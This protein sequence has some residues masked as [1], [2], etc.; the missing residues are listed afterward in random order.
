MH[1]FLVLLGCA[2]AVAAAASADAA[3]TEDPLIPLGRALFFDI[4]L[5]TPAG[6]SCSSC[7]DP[8]V[9]FSDPERDLP[10]SRGVLEDR[11]GS[12]NAQSVAYAAFSPPLH[13]DPTPQPG[14]HQGMYVGGF[15]WDG[16][17][18]T[19]EEQAKEPFLNPLE[20]HNPDKAAVV[21]SVRRAVYAS[22][23]DVACGAGA[24][25][26]VEA[27]F[28]CVAKALAA[29]LRSPALSPFT[30][31][32][33][34][35]RAGRTTLTPAEAR[36]YELFTGKAKCKNCHAT[37]P[38]PEG[39]ILFTNFGHHNTGVPRNPDLPFYRLPASL[40]PVGEK[41]VDRGL[42]DA[43]RKAGAAEA[44]AVRE[45]GKFKVPSLRNVAVTPP[46]MHN[47]VFKTLREVVVFNNTRDVAG[48]PPPE[49]P[50]NVHR[51][52]GAPGASRPAA[53]HGTQGQM[54]VAHQHPA[55]AEGTFGRLGL[56]DQEVDDLV[57]FLM[58]LTD[59]YQPQ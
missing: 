55:S 46:Y 1:R 45:D 53:G 41:H 2:C 37:E 47:G 32:F 36:G 57:A 24:L 58:T 22:G 50:Q 13:Y 38:G 6:Q 12:R 42:G 28:D 30:A 26:G 23:L 10:V 35:W 48:G 49:V 17:A 51:H 5:S 33:D 27:A 21:A 39:R 52:M 59:G 19:L 29:Y 14:T 9:G 7:H 16:R 25:A 40:N 44:D 15:F 54:A 43:L 34:L 31:K 11:V 3:S 18:K 8:Q 20:M 56:T 4:S